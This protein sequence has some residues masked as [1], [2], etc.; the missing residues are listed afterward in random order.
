MHEVRKLDGGV[1]TSTSPGRA[2]P[3]EGDG[4]TDSATEFFDDLARRGHE[5]LLEKAQGRLRIE[6]VNGKKTDRWLVS[7]DRGDISVS[8]RNEKADCV[9]RTNGALFG[10]I[11][12]GKSNAVTAVLRGAASAEGDLELLFLLQRIFPA[13]TPPRA[14]RRRT[15]RGGKDL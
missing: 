6:L 9:F 8:R 3:R 14:R 13:P 1:L 5:P 4:M 2:Q 11:V 12:H 7:F 10:R 15:G